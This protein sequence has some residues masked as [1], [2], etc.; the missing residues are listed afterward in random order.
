MSKVTTERVMKGVFFFILTVAM[1]LSAWSLTT[2]GISYGM[3]MAFAVLI[4]AAIDGAGIMA[5]Y[6][7]STYARS[8]YSGLG[9]KVITYGLVGVSAWLNANHAMMLGYGIPGAILFAA[10][11]VIVGVLLDMELK[12]TGKEELVKNGHVLERLPI[13]GRLAW[14]LFPSDTFKG[15]KTVVK[16]RLDS[17]VNGFEARQE[18]TTEATGT[19]QAIAVN[20]DTDDSRNDMQA[21]DLVPEVIEAKRHDKPE[22]DTTQAVAPKRQA[23]RQHDT[24]GDREDDK[25]DDTT[26]LD[27]IFSELDKTTRLS[28]LVTVALENGHND[29]DALQKAA[30]RHLGIEVKRST[31]NT[32]IQ[33]YNKKNAQVGMYL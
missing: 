27:D 4:S 28:E 18:A 3:P 7:A 30:E 29:R 13:F 21:I 16:R 26:E 9:P 19:T 25:H 23:T 17:A 32:C 31:L 10:P 2:L 6:R 12:W 20:D 24:T 8:P 33:R 22:D 11:A 1:L 14:V 15:L 5:G